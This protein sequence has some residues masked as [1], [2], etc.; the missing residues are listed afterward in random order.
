MKK[1]TWVLMIVACLLSTSLSS[2]LSFG[3]SEKITDSWKFILNDEKEAQ[4]IS[5]NDSKWKVLD[6]PHDWSV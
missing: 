4:S 2:Q 5:F 3:Y 6:L 1:L